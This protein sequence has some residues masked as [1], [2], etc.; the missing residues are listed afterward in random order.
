MILDVPLIMMS[1]TTVMLVAM[2]A[3]GFYAKNIPFWA[4][5]MKYLSFVQYAYFSL[6][7]IDIHNI[8]I[9]CAKVGSLYPAC[10]NRTEEMANMTR[11]IPKSDLLNAYTLHSA[12]WQLWH[13]LIIIVGTVVIMRTATYITLRFIRKPNVA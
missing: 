3:G 8:D 10:F 5:W 6:V 4:E 7:T 12:G 9:E 2:L 11:Y 1:S 13:Y